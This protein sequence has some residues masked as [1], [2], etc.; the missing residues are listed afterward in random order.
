MARFFADI[1]NINEG[2]IG[3]TDEDMRHIRSL[4]LRP[5]E[6]FTVCDGCCT[7]HTCAMSSEAGVAKIL[8]SAPTRGE[9][10]GVYRVYA[11]FSKSDRMEY[12]IQKTVELGVSEIILFPSRRCVVSYDGTGL[13]KKLDRWR[14]IALEAAKQ[15][16]RGIIPTVRMAGNYETA[17]DEAAE[18]KIALYCYELEES[19]RLR[20]VLEHMDMAETVSIVTGPEGG[21]EEKEAGYALSRGMKTITLGERIL[22]CETAPVA[23]LAAVMYHFGNI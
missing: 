16:G 20:E 2:L 12:V 18:S 14:K 5:G 7:D 23:V 11:A 17:I 3:L 13:A 8:S 21:F 19:T 22:R 6:T 4:R 1:D 10:V 15:C 9:P